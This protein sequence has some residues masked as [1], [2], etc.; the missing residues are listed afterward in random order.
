MQHLANISQNLFGMLTIRY[1]L[2][3]L[4]KNFIFNRWLNYGVEAT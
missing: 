1:R 4:C 3:D 2:I